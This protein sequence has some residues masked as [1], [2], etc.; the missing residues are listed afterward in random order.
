MAENGQKWTKM[1]KIAFSDLT[2]CLNQ[3]VEENKTALE[4]NFTH[5]MTKSTS[6]GFKYGRKRLKMAKN[7]QKLNKN[8]FSELK[9]CSNQKI[10]EN[11]PAL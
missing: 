8:A 3:N 6:L 9:N 2:E 4:L 1:I 11:K 10:E 5:Y 7:D